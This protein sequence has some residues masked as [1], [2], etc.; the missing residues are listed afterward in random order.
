MEPPSIEA[1]TEGRRTIAHAVDARHGPGARRASPV[2]R[3]LEQRVR[4]ADRPSAVLAVHVRAARRCGRSRTNASSWALSGSWVST[5][6]SSDVA[7]E[8]RRVAG[9]QLRVGEVRPGERQA[10]GE[11]VELEH[12]LL[13]DHRRAGAAWPA[14]ASSRRASRTRPTGSGGGRTAGP[15][16]RRAC[17]G[18]APRRRASAARRRPS[19]A[20][21]RRGWRGRPSRRRRGCGPGTGPPAGSRWRRSW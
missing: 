2:G 21:R 19:S 11:V 8:R 14:S 10:L 6:I 17:A 5:S 15:R 7:G 4:D 18:R 16:A 1:P 13:A 3:R 20:C 12:A 9:D